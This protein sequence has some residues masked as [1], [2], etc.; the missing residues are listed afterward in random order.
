MDLHSLLDPEQGKNNGFYNGGVVHSFLPCNE[1]A[2]GVQAAQ[3]LH[4]EETLQC[5]ID[6]RRSDNRAITLFCLV[7]PILEASK[8]HFQSGISFGGGGGGNGRRGTAQH[9]ETYNVFRQWRCDTQTITQ[10]RH[11]ILR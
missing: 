10:M 3:D 6:S 4:A 11:H 9:S 7:D 1:G 2:C 5:W 8:C